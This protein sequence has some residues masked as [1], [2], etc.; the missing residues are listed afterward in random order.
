[1]QGCLARRPTGA[2]QGWAG[3]DPVARATGDPAAAGRVAANTAPGWGDGA[4][5]RITAALVTLAVTFHQGGQ[6][7]SSRLQSGRGASLQSIGIAGN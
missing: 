2:D 3:L 7:R 4:D 5:E 1:M 6:S